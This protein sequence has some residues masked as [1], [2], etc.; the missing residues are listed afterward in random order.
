[1]R[2]EDTPTEG[3]LSPR[4]VC[5]LGSGG[6]C[7]SSLGLRPRQGLNGLSHEAAVWAHVHELMGEPTAARTAARQGAVASYSLPSRT[8]ED[9]GRDLI[10]ISSCNA[11]SG[12][13]TKLTF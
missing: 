10:C 9:L 5:G 1:M 8:N 4:L 13:K 11:T 3:A 6:P 12:L 2:E 7:M